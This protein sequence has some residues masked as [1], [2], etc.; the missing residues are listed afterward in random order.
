MQPSK[1][2]MGNVEIRYAMAR[3]LCL[4]LQEKQL[5]N[6]YYQ[7]LRNR[8]P[9]DASGLKAFYGT[10]RTDNANTAAKQFRVWLEQS[11]P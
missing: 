6:A 1:F 4:F 2:R 11:H 5:L 3:S 9:N 7:A 10:L 8:T